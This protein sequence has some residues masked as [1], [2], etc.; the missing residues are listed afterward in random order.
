VEVRAEARE[1]CSLAR[2]AYRTLEDLELVFR[3]RGR[4]LVDCDGKRG[5]AVAGHDAE[6]AAEDRWAAARETRRRRPLWK[7]ATPWREP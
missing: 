6:H 7:R 2:G 3:Q 1:P 5:L 4:D